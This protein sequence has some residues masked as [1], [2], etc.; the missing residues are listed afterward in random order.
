MP[1]EDL[2]GAISL[3]AAVNAG[4]VQAIARRGYQ[5]VEGTCPVCGV[6]PARG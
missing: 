1:K 2:E 3:I 6:G 5:H 4:V